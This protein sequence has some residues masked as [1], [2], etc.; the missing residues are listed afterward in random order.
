ML[1]GRQ[2]KRHQRADGQRPGERADTAHAHGPADAGRADRGRIVDRGERDEAGAAAAHERAEQSLQQNDHAD[3]RRRIADQRHRHGAAEHHQRQDDGGAGARRSASRQSDVAITLP[4]LN[5]AI[6]SEASLMPMP[7]RLSKV[8]AQAELVT[9]IMKAMKKLIHNRNGAGGAAHGEKLHDRH[10]ARALFVE[11]E[12]GA[13]RNGHGWKHLPQQRRYL[14]R[15]ALPL[16]TRKPT[17][18]GRATISATQTK[19]GSTPPT[20]NTECQP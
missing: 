2:A 12:S 14:L 13:G 17:D 5:I 18:S 20:Q 15:P 10:A 19:S 1:R 16:A 8:G 6:A 9:S 11:D 4:R 7:S 3:R